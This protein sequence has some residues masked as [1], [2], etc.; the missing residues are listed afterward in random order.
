MMTLQQPII[1]PEPDTPPPSNSTSPS[2]PGDEML[3]DFPPILRRSRTEMY[4]PR[5]HVQFDY[6]DAH[7]QRIAGEACIGF[8]DRLDALISQFLIALPEH[9][10]FSEQSLRITITNQP[11]QL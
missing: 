5:V 6:L 2:D 8:Q 10:N 3:P 4:R 1:H 9:F 7:D 11:L